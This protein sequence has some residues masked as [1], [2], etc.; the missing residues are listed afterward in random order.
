M[1]G[2]NGAVL[3]IPNL[4]QSDEGEYYCIVTN[5]WGN[6]ESTG[7]V[8]LSIQGM[9]CHSIETYLPYTVQLHVNCVEMKGQELKYHPKVNFMFTLCSFAV[10]IS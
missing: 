9:H 8:N 7:D 2:V 3:T 5:E 10:S 6:S 4:V 1:S